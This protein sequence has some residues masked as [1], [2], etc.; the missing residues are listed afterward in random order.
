M[1]E[2]AGWN[3]GSRIRR[4]QQGEANFLFCSKIF[5]TVISWGLFDSFPVMVE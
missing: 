2:I 5:P 4:V 1:S 3:F